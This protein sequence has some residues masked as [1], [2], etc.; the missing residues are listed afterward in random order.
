MQRTE[1]EYRLQINLQMS[2]I[3]EFFLLWCNEPMTCVQVLHGPLAAQ[4]KLDDENE[5][6]T[7]ILNE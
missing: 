5:G 1:P 2:L 3:F 4:V 7:P 6:S